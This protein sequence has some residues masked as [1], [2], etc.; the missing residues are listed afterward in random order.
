[1]RAIYGLMWLSLATSP[2]WA[3]C[4]G[5]GR[6][7]SSLLGILLGILAIFLLIG[8]VLGAAL[9]EGMLLSSGV[10]FR[11]SRLLWSVTFGA[12]ITALF[13]VLIGGA[14]GSLGLVAPLLGG[15]ASLHKTSSLGRSAQPVD[16]GEEVGFNR[17]G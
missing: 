4:C 11:L 3:G 7:D 13:G 1:M 10:R 8:P 6:G 14:F 12:L 2:A 15:L 17:E 5:S 16:H 9:G